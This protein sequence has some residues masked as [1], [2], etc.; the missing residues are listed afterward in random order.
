MATWLVDTLT[1]TSTKGTSAT[2]DSTDDVE[3][4]SNK[5]ERVTTKALAGDVETN[6]SDILFEDAGGQV[7][8]TVPIRSG[9]FNTNPTPVCPAP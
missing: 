1:R 4:T 7:S 9:L 5:G 2:T 6:G 8:F 3:T